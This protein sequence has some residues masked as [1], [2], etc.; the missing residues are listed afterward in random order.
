MIFSKRSTGP[1]LADS[2]GFLHNQGTM[3]HSYVCLEAIYVCPNGDWKLGSME[4][5]CKSG[6]FEDESFLRA[7]NQYLDRDYLPPERDRFDDLTIQ[8]A[9]G[10]IDIY[11]AAVCMQKIF[12]KLVDT[13]PQYTKYLKAMLRGEIERRPKAR[14]VLKSDIFQFDHIVLMDKVAEMNTKTNIELCEVLDM[15]NGSDPNSLSGFLVSAKIA[16]ALE[17]IYKVAIKDFSVREAREMCRRL[18]TDATT[19]L[20][21]FAELGKID[22]AC[23]EKRL[24]GGLCGGGLYDRA[25]GP[26]CW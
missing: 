13:P 18:I 25:L 15:L 12:N 6:N 9:K 7:H 19:L 24:C 3:T 8:R 11:S 2:I 14:Q 4:L 26:V 16:P 22:A 20:S 17:H 5:S 21:N 1:M 23:F 10:A